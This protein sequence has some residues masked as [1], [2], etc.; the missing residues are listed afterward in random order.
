MAQW[1]DHPY[2]KIAQ[3][4]GRRRWYEPFRL[5]VAE[6]LEGA[7]VLRQ[8]AFDREPAPRD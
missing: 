4:E 1:R 3:Q 2:H 5:E 8:T 7:E 6:R